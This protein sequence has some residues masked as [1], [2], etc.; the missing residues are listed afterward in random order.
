MHER[1]PERDKN[2]ERALRLVAGLSESDYPI[3]A[4]SGRP[5][6]TIELN[7]A[8]NL[9]W[10]YAHGVSVFY[11]NSQKVESG[12]EALWE[13][14]ESIRQ[15]I[16]A[17][18]SEVGSAINRA[19][20]LNQAKYDEAVETGDID[21]FMDAA[22]A[23]QNTPREQWARPALL[24]SVERFQEAVTHVIDKS[25]DAGETVQSTGRR[26]NWAARNIAFT[27]ASFANSVTGEIPAH[28]GPYGTTPLERSVASVLREVGIKSDARR[29][30]EW[31]LSKL[32]ENS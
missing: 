20:D 15:R 5:K 18:P 28:R 30:T 11:S 13:E 1:T 2:I 17:L 32:Q 7:K 25:N 14:L 27:V 21:A 26:P 12:L 4:N 22:R 3:A 10:V 24:A 9:V 29:P 6:W 16:R 23:I 8:V 31:A 19:A